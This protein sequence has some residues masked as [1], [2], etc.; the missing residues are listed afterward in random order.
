MGDFN[1]HHIKIPITLAPIHSRIINS[2]TA[3]KLLY[4]FSSLSSKLPLL[5]DTD[6]L[7]NSFNDLCLATLDPVAPI[8]TRT[9]LI[10]KTWFSDHSCSLKRK[11]CKIEHK[12]KACKLHVHYEYM[13]DLMKKYN[14]VLNDA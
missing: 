1:I 6:Q 14:A 4:A 11:V 2:T 12:W 8:K 7:V 3:T 10:T 13:K 9:K 5:P